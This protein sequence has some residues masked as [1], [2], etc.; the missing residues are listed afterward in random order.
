M[1]SNSGRHPT[2]LFSMVTAAILNFFNPQ[3]L[4][5]FWNL[6]SLF[7]NLHV[8]VKFLEVPNKF[9]N[10]C[11]LVTMTTSAILNFI[12][13]PKVSTH[14]GEFSYDVS[15]SLMKEIKKYLKSSLFYFHG[16]CS[17]VCPTDSDSF[18]LSR[19]TRCGCDRKH[20]CKNLWS[21]EWI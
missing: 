3:K 2:P 12:N 11:T 6:I 9:N 10:F 4:Q 5:P 15:W 16:N 7:A 17:K 18:G 20:Y 13:T 8:T 14:Y 1:Q 21:L 19:S